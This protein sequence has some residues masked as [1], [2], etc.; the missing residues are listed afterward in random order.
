M[1]SVCLRPLMKSIH[2]FSFPK[3]ESS[4]RRVLHCQHITPPTTVISTIPLLS[5]DTGSMDRS[6]PP[7]FPKSIGGFISEVM[8]P[9]NVRRE[10]TARSDKISITYETLHKILQ[11]HETLI[12]KRW[13]KR[14]RRQRLK[15]LLSAWPNMPAMHRPDL[16]ALVEHSKSIYRDSYIWPYIN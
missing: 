9:A 6:D 3:T 12:R 5:L 4:T 10:P 15:I 13:T 14:T 2:V 11:R 1:D 8:S 7:T 16:Q